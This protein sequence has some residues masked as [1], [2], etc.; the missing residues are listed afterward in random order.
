MILI[1][2]GSIEELIVENDSADIELSDC[3]IKTVTVKKPD[4]S[5][6]KGST[7]E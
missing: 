2:N 4:T 6:H 1:K 3:H 7:D 5:E